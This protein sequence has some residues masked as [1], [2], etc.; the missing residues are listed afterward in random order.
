MSDDVA[1]LVDEINELL[2]AGR[3][4]LYEFA[5]ILLERHPDSTPLERRPMC[6]DALD[7]LLRDPAIRL[8]WYVWASGLDPEPA[9]I[10]DVRPETFDEIGPDPYLGIERV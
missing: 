6:R 8:G 1:W 10:G 9:T 2:R 7:Q 4:G 3:V 5:D